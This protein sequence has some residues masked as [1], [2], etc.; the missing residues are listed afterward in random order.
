MKRMAQ[1]M[2]LLSASFTVSAAPIFHPAGEN[3]TY[4]SLSNFQSLVAHTNNPAVGASALPTQEWNFGFGLL[5][6]IGIGYEIGPVNDLTEQWQ[7]L[8]DRLTAIEDSGKDPTIDDINA[9]KKDFDG[10]LVTAGDSGYVGLHLGAQIPLFPI[11]WNSRDTLGGSLVLDANA[12]VQAQFRFLDRPIEYNPLEQGVNALQTN[13]SAYLKVAAVAEYSLDFSRPIV[14]TDSG[15]LYAG[16]RANVYQVEL[17]KLILSVAQSDNIDKVLEDET[18][19][20]KL[21]ADTGFGI[22]LG[23]IWASDNYRVGA[24]FKNVN[25]PS[26]E[27]DP[28]G[29][30]CDTETGNSQDSCYIE[31]SFANEIDLQE[32]WVMDAQA[33]IEFAFYNHSRNWYLG[34]SSD[35]S[36]VHDPVANEVQWFTASA[37][38]A[39]GSWWIPG[40]RFGYRKNL[41]GT[42]LSSATAGFTLFKL[43]HLDAAYGL[44]SISVDGNEIPRSAQVNL[45]LDLLF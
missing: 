31:K 12:A 8:S 30:S 5:S 2:A 37:G 15:A 18:N 17:R 3:L 20:L 36:P 23:L 19:D 7:S 41:A 14:E 45:G 9:I 34:V 44:E 24:S 35:V 6:S 29:V 33:N 40:I 1:I 27:Y 42:Q 28:V 16:V 22:D 21:T 39:T 10:F 38:Y 11:I 43:L 32:T 26:F 4:G 13:S 25:A